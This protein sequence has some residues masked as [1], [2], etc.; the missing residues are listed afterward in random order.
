D[1]GTGV[2]DALHK[3]LPP[4]RTPVKKPPGNNTS[5]SK[6]PPEGPPLAPKPVARVGDTVCVEGKVTR[7]FERKEIIADSLVKSSSIND[8]PRHWLE[9]HRLHKENYDL[10]TPFRIPERPLSPEKSATINVLPYTPVKS[11]PPVG[12]LITNTNLPQTSMS[13][14]IMTKLSSNATPST[15]NTTPSTNYSTNLSSSQASSPARSTAAQ[16]P[17]RLRHP[18]RLHSRDLNSNTFRIYVKHYM[19]RTAYVHP[20]AEESGNESD[21]NSINEFPAS[22]SK[23]SVHHLIDETPRPSSRAP[24]SMAT[25]RPRIAPISY[26]AQPRPQLSSV[27]NDRPNM[28]GFTLSY[29]RR[30]PE[31]ADMAQRVVKAV[32]KRRLREERQKAKEAAAAASTSRASSSTHQKPSTSS[33]SRAN[34]SS[35]SIQ[36]E[37]KSGPRIKRLFQAT[38]VQLLREGSIVLW[39]GPTHPCPT[40]GVPKEQISGLWKANVTS[41]SADSTLFSMTSVSMAGEG[42]VLVLSDPESNE[43]AYIPIS[44]EFL[45]GVVEEAIGKMTRAPVGAKGAKRYES[46]T[47]DGILGYLRKDDRWRYLSE[48]NVGEA[49]DVLKAEQRAW[50]VARGVWELSL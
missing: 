46:S 41:T 14:G 2:I 8:E 26:G 12:K 17:Q 30:V 1:D 29:L 31:L 18:S 35:S 23:R 34:A 20:Q 36:I 15:A 32:T 10:S 43:E 39:D 4:P 44:P 5:S 28:K 27:T 38:I 48:W 25:P 49:L 9:V 24:L 13:R 16:S 11:A 47:K 40:A 3:S 19:D 37:G 7:K 50:C 33:S 6:P 45:A 22:P 21:T 42:E